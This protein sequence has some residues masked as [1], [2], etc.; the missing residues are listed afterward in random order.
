[1]DFQFGKKYRKREGKAN[2]SRIISNKVR[3]NFGVGSVAVRR[4]G[5]GGAP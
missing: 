3:T 1:M 4:A 5:W 2:I